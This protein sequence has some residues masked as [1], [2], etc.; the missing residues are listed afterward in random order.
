MCHMENNFPAAFQYQQLVVFFCVRMSCLTRY[1]L[2]LVITKCTDVSVPSGRTVWPSVFITWSKAECIVHGVNY[3]NWAGLLRVS[4]VALPLS[5]C[6]R[7]TC[8]VF[9]NLVVFFFF[10]FLKEMLHPI[11]P[12]L[13]LIALWESPSYCKNIVLSFKLLNLLKVNKILFYFYCPKSQ[14]HLLLFLYCKVR[15]IG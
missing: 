2:S 13:Q 6:P 12:T 15:I 10:L 11:L 9:S 14:Q 7:V 5:Q 1:N 8:P 3:W 4:V